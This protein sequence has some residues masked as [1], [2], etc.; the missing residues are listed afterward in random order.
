MGDVNWEKFKSEL[1]KEA[2]VVGMGNFGKLTGREQ[3]GSLYRWIC[4]AMDKATRRFVKAKGKK[5]AWWTEELKH[6]KGRVA[7]ARK[8]WQSSRKELGRLEGN[9]FNSSEYQGL[10]K[11]YKKALKE[12][13]VSWWRSFVGTVGNADP[14]GA[15]YKLCRRE[16]SEG[17]VGVWDGDRKTVTWG[18]TVEVLLDEFF[19]VDVPVNYGL[20]ERKESTVERVSFGGIERSVG[21]MRKRK[22]AGMDGITPEMMDAVWKV[23]PE[24]VMEL[25]NACMRE[26]WV[27]EEWRIARLVIFLKGIDK[28]RFLKRSYRPICLLSVTGKAFERVL[29]ERL[30]KVLERKMSRAQFGFVKGVGIQDAWM[31]VRQVVEESRKKYVM[32]VFVDFKG[33]FDNLRWS[34]VLSKLVEVGCKEIKCWVSYFR[35]RRVCVVGEADEIERKV[36][37]GCP[38]GTVGDISKNAAKRQTFIIN[39]LKTYD[40]ISI[41]NKLIRNA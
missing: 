24:Y 16:R 30:G 27:P 25:F 20:Y 29:V 3:L 5:A 22:S 17:L 28:Y 35:D 11:E 26:G 14:W 6:L 31:R 9:R 21:S 40:S 8:R 36:N 19:P 12:A 37:K 34:D 33:A 41:T 23:V 18:E 13:K 15:V 38:Q 10:L 39:I 7:K 4:I 1:E 32:G 2:G